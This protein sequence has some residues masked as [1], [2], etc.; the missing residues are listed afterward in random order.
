VTD[1]RNK[2]AT[3]TVVKTKS[4]RLQGIITLPSGKRKRLPP[5]PAG[6]SEAMAREKTAYFAE[7]LRAMPVVVATKVPMP[8]G[9]HA[10]WDA[11]FAHR[12]A[13]GLSSVEDVFVHLAPIVGTKDPRDW[14]A[15]DCEAVRDSL[16]TKIDAGSW[17]HPSGRVYRFG[18]KRAWNVWALFTSACKAACRSKNRALRVRKDNPCDGV[19]PPDRGETKIKQWLYPEE[20][21][22]LVSEPSVPQ[23]WRVF[24]ALLTYTYV[25]PNELA[26]IRWSDVDLDK[27]VIGVSKAYDFKKDEPK[28]YPKTSKGVRKVPIEPELMPLLN[29]L[30][31]GAEPSDTV[32][33]NLPPAEDWAATLRDHLKRAGVDRA[34]LFENTKTVKHI[35]LY[36]LRATGISW[37]CLRKDY[38]PDIQRNAGH[39]KYATTEG[40]IRDV[41]DYVGKVGKPFPAL[42]DI[43]LSAGGSSQVIDHPKRFQQENR[44][45]QRDSNPCYSLERAVSWA[46]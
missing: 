16:D 33:P 23:R 4:G 26:A 6:T 5:F 1:K 43:L 15:D 32:L 28:P 3:G 31:E 21:S 17:K 20:F 19:E 41:Q 7:K 18:W 24:Y 40:Y 14:T 45:P 37:R 44:R 30:R 22:K 42:P 27:G 38:G 9:R 35:T 10:W 46:G 11:Y 29:Y 34:A 36:D 39:E 2:P 13:K 12:E 25:R 8:T